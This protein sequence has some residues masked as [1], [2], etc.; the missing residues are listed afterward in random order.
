M[1]ESKGTRPG[2]W[3][4][5]KPVQ[6][7]RVGD[8]I[9]HPHKSPT[10]WFEITEYADELPESLRYDEHF[11]GQ[12]RAADGQSYDLTFWG[13]DTYDTVLM[14]TEFLVDA[15]GLVYR[16]EPSG[17]VSCWSEKYGWHESAFHNLRECDDYDRAHFAD[18][19]TLVTVEQLPVGA[20]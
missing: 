17:V 8:V 11:A 2:S 1:T 7:L 16:V 13:Q 6:A 20:R 14:K 18:H 15:D 19:L 3:Y 9:R 12:G 4:M 5:P 10:M